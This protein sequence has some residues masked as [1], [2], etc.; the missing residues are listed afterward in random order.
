MVSTRRLRFKK[1]MAIIA[2]I[3]VYLML[4]FMYAPILVLVVF[5][6]TNATLIG[7]WNGFSL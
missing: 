3:F 1:A 2:K 4:L 5:S 6:F 7:N